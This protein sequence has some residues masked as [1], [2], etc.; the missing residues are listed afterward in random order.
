MTAIPNSFAYSIAR[1]H[2]VRIGNGPSVI[3][4]RDG[5]RRHHLP[6]LREL[7]SLHPLGGGT[8]GMHPRLSGDSGLIQ[9]VLGHRGAV[10]HRLGVRHR[11]DAR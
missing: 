6:D 1:T 11:G 5:A 7:S 10:V 2:D 4:D 9:N 8:Y 3:R